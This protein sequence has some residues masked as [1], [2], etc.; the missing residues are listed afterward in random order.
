MIKIILPFNIVT[1]YNIY[2]Y[3]YIISL[4]IVF[5]LNHSEIGKFIEK[6]GAPDKKN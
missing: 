4:M 2:Y 3:T 5:H 6:A 1:S